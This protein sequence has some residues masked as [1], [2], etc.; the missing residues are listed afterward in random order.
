MIKKRDECL[1][2]MMPI[3]LDINMQ[4]QNCTLSESQ[5]SFF[6]KHHQMLSN[7]LKNFKFVTSTLM[8]SF[9]Y[10]VAGKIMSYLVKTSNVYIVETNGITAIILGIPND[11]IYIHELCF[12]SHR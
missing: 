9:A 10:G 12:L 2:T 7:C 11:R 6:V 4:Y 1:G 8:T 5:K 3:F